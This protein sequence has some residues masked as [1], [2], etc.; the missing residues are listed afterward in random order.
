MSSFSN[1]VN[2]IKTD[3]MNIWDELLITAN[4]GNPTF[5]YHESALE[6]WRW[7]RDFVTLWRFRTSWGTIEWNLE[8]VCI[9]VIWLIAYIDFLITC[10]YMYYTNSSF[11]SFSSFDLLSLAEMWFIIFIFILLRNL[12]AIHTIVIQNLSLYITYFEIE[13][14][15]FKQFTNALVRC[16]FFIEFNQIEWI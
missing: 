12:F 6:L 1:L 2:H 15:F 8:N 3:F 5:S 13:N 10:F 9:H 11:F 7:A 4:V 14:L 16:Q